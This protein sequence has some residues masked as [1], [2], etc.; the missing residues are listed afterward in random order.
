MLARP[1]PRWA[2]PSVGAILLLVALLCTMALARPAVQ[3]PVQGPV[4]Q[5]EQRAVQ[6][7][8]LEPLRPITQK[9]LPRSE[10]RSF[11]ETKLWE[12]NPPDEIEANQVRWAALGYI[13]PDLDLV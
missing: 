11:L 4:E 6:L 10:L 5:I 2:L 9:S 7:R 1:R 12:D 13:S 8:E 3:A